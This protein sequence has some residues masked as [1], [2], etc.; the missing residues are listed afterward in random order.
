MYGVVKQVAAEGLL[1]VSVARHVYLSEL[2]SSRWSRSVSRH[3]RSTP[4]GLKVSSRDSQGPELIIGPVL[5]QRVYEGPCQ[6]E[7]M[8]RR[9]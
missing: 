3:R 6:G 5:R 7:Q 1:K 9:S 8:R 2:K 4:T